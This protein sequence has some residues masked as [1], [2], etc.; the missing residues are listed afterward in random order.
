MAKVSTKG[1]IV[2]P[3]NLRNNIKVGDEFL[4]V[5]DNER[6]VLKNMKGLASDLKDDLIFAERVDKAW[7][8][9]DKGKFIT[10][11]KEEFLKELRLC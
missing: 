1:Q 8:E 3:S 9:Y 10:K 4:M 6:I 7:K 11:T 2:I 5:K